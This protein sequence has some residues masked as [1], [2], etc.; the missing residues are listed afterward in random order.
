MP[1]LSPRKLEFIS[2]EVTYSVSLLFVSAFLS[3]IFSIMGATLFYGFL[4]EKSR[5]CRVVLSLLWSSCIMS[6]FTLVVTSFGVLWCKLVIEDWPVLRFISLSMLPRISCSSV[7]VLSSRF[8]M[9]SA[10]LSF[11]SSVNMVK[12]FLLSDCLS[13]YICYLNY[14]SIMREPHNS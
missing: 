2:S 1:S 9:P 10:P 7:T 5:R 12:V 4:N 8:A 3:G 6:A 14:Y 13:A 11:S